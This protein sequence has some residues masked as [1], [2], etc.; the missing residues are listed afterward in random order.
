MALFG[1]QRD[2]NLFKTVTRELMGDVI[3][4][5]ASF[6]KPDYASTE[7]NIY[8]ESS[9]K[10][11]WIGPVIFN[12]IVDRRDQEY[13]ESDKGVDFSWG[14]TFKF[15]KEDLENASYLADV[16]DVIFY[17]NGYYEVDKIIA[18]QYITGKDN[19][20]PNAGNPLNPELDKFGSNYSIVCETH[21]V[22]GDKLGIDQVRL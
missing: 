3:S 6:Y 14:I 10:R 4:Q 20:Y 13:P 9:S 12:C 17:R 21:Y 18:N 22:P 8:G 19:L 2:I 7:S 16:G 1:R 5:Q 11:M 15:L